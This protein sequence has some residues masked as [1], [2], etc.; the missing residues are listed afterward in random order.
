MVPG[1]PDDGRAVAPPLTSRQLAPAADEL[2]AYRRSER[3]AVA[4]SSSAAEVNVTAA[5]TPPFNGEAALMDFGAGAPSEFGDGV[6]EGGRRRTGRYRPAAES[7]GRAGPSCRASQALSSAPAVARPSAPGN[8][9]G[10]MWSRASRHAVASMPS[11]TADASS[12][13]R[14]GAPRV[15]GDEQPEPEAEVAG[16]DHAAEE[17]GPALGPVTAGHCAANEPRRQ[18]DTTPMAVLPPAKLTAR[19][20]RRCGAVGRRCSA[21]C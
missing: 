19:S 20:H 9:L 14:T 21:R 17:A 15:Q 10:R 12:Q 11:T 5:Q 7:G 18:S 1:M 4:S 13:P 2:R 16:A 8:T 6:R 3:L